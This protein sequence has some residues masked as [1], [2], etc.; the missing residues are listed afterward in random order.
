MHLTSEEFIQDPYPSYRRLRQVEGGYWLELGEEEASG[1]WLFSRYGD[2]SALLR[3]ATQ[4]SKRTNRVAPDGQ[5]LPFDQ[6]MLSNDPPEHR[7]L[8]DLAVPA[9]SVERL[10]FLEQQ[11]RQRVDALLDVVLDK[12]TCDFMS[13]VAVPV[14]L[15]VAAMLLGVP[16]QDSQQ[17]RDWTEQLL[18]SFDSI[19]TKTTTLRASEHWMQL[20]QDYFEQALARPAPPPGSILDLLSKRP[21][22]SRAEAVGLCLLLV[23]A[24]YETTVHL[25]GNGLRS[26]LRFPDQLQLLREQ[27]ELLDSAI[28]EM[29]RFESPLQRSTFRIVREAIEIGGRQLQPGTQVAALF[30]AA[31]RDETQFPDAERFDIRRNPN[32]HMAFGVGVHRC[33]GERLARLEA[34]LVFGR[35]LERTSEMDLQTATPRYRRTTMFRSLESLPVSL[36]PR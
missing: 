26:L 5:K 7:R 9:F 19:I 24:G 20:L 33:L 31:N 35:L 4:I 23:V 21:D 18:L 34:K 11:L 6:M 32:R 10:A 29:L 22:A 15:S 25:L 28:E 30:G 36:K 27:P 16:E 8:R 1:L 3:E 13:E 12:R 14:P 17:L 2:V